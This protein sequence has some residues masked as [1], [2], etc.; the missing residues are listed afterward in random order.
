MGCRQGFLA[1][2]GMCENGN[3]PCEMQ[4]CNLWD[5]DNSD[6][7]DYQNPDYADYMDENYD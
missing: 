4:K 5:N 6:G 3:R 1:S 2:N 7:S